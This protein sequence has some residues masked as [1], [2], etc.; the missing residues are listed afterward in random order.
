MV[1]VEKSQS[2]ID[3][4]TLNVPRAVLRHSMLERFKEA[5]R[6]V[7]VQNKIHLHQLKGF[8]V[9]R[10]AGAMMHMIP[11]LRI[12]KLESLKEDVTD[13]FASLDLA[14]TVEM[15]WNHEFKFVTEE[16]TTGIWEDHKYDLPE[17]T[18]YAT[19][20]LDLHVY[21]RGEYLVASLPSRLPV[22]ARRKF[23]TSSRGI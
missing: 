4:P 1:Q 14:F 9:A 5:A 18:T 2:E 21:A 16:S 13:L 6:Q 17:T 23:T 12:S 22:Q 11:S 20:T 19:N 8:R 10:G 15:F 3:S 7:I